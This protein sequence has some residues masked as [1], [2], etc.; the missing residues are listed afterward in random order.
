[1]FTGLIESTGEFRSRLRQGTSAKLEIAAGFPLG[2]IEL[3]ESIAVNGACLTVE[4]VDSAS[5]SLRFHCLSETLE[6]T[7]LGILSPGSV[8][9]LE[10]ALCLGGRL[11]GHLVQ[12][13]VD[14]TAEIFDIGTRGDDT[15]FCI[16]LPDSIAPLVI[17]KGSIAVDGIS[18]T[19]AELKSD[20]FAV[21]VIP[22]TWANTNLREASDG[23][24]VNLEADLVG[25][26]VLRQG[27]GKTGGITMGDLTSAGFIG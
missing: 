12:G 17:H 8:V 16:A 21:H 11:G 7:S 15:V 27:R 14:C 24:L 22:H 19:I 25:K 9:N 23:D 10:R 3:G 2:D 20:S 18:L 1:M 4:E 6:R 26:Y 13:H 5:G